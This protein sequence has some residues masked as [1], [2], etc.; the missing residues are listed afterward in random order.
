MAEGDIFDFTHWLKRSSGT[1]IGTV[2]GTSVGLR[3]NIDVGSTW[4]VL[5][6]DPAHVQAAFESSFSDFDFAQ[7]YGVHSWAAG[8]TINL[9]ITGLS[10]GAGLVAVEFLKE[11]GKDLW[12]A[13]KSL[14]P[15]TAN[16][17]SD[18]EITGDASIRGIGDTISLTLVTDNRKVFTNVSLPFKDRATAAILKDFC[19]DAP[20]N[21][22]LK[23]LERIKR[24]APL[25]E[26]LKVKHCRRKSVDSIRS[27]QDFSQNAST[28]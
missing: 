7:E 20:V 4:Y 19:K 18:A 21:L 16:D 23:E 9:I 17:K 24:D 25:S 27:W 2:A 15:N 5:D 22:F 13:F 3:A 12:K 10:A 28:R 26:G 8:T 6:V 1:G 11:A 14:L